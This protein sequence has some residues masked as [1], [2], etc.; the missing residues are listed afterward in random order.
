M[1]TLPVA[2][3]GW[4][5]APAPSPVLVN[6]ASVRGASGLAVAFGAIALMA[7]L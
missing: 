3:G 4:V 1:P 6:A 7:A 2:T 5:G